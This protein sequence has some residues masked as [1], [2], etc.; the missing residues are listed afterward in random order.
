MFCAANSKRRRPARE[1][2]RH[3]RE[4]KATSVDQVSNRN[5]SMGKLPNKAFE[6][7]RRAPDK[8][9]GSKHCGPTRAR[10]V[11][12]RKGNK[13]MDF[14]RLLSQMRY[15]QPQLWLAGQAPSDGGACALAIPRRVMLARLRPVLRRGGGRCGFAKRP[16]VSSY[17][18]VQANSVLYSKRCDQMDDLP[19]L[20]GLTYQSGFHRPFAAL[21]PCPAVGRNVLCRKDKDHLCRRTPRVVRGEY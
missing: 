5:F 15:A 21:R 19:G 1:D 9:S 7:E 8:D 6:S 18:K 4:W 12:K 13:I 20:K 17:K 10:P 11:R 3:F 16:S 14:L 2:K